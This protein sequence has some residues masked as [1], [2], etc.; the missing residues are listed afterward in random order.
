[1]IL[2]K[3]SGRSPALVKFIAVGRY[4]KFVPGM[5]LHCNKYQAH[6]NVIRMQRNETI[7]NGSLEKLQLFG[8][9][10]EGFA[11][12]WRN[13]QLS[14]TVTVFGCRITNVG[15][16]AVTAKLLGEFVHKLVSVGLC[17]DRCCGDR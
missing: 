12:V 14:Y 2:P 16:P 17:Q 4:D 5:I 15:F 6:V 9:Q 13:A 7:R 8:Q 10:C 1:M 3:R 11:M